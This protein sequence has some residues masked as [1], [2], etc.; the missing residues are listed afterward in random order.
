MAV[1]AEDMVPEGQPIPHERMFCTRYLDSRCNM[2][3]KNNC[4]RVHWVECKLMREA[5]ESGYLT[6]R[7]SS[8]IITLGLRTTEEMLALFSVSMSGDSRMSHDDWCD[9]R[10]YLHFKQGKEHRDIL[11]PDYT[12]AEDIVIFRREPSFRAKRLRRL[13]RHRRLCSGARTKGLER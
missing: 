3:K 8:D 10:D 6:A 12:D 4:N 7:M 1:I 9:F 13:K 5:L 2:A 11:E